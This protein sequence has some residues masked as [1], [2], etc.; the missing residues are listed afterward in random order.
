MCDIG[1]T[2]L[3]LCPRKLVIAAN[4]KIFWLTLT[5]PCKILYTNKRSKCSLRSS[6]VS[7]FNLVNRSPY[8]RE[9]IPTRRRVNRRCTRSIRRSTSRCVDTVRGADELKER[10]RRC[11]CGV[12][13]RNSSTAAWA[14]AAVVW[15]VF[16]HLFGCFRTF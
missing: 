6:S 16:V 15:L 7:K 10:E 14:K 2:S 1:L 3:Q 4:L 13:K 11:I 5:R 12:S 9:P 8:V